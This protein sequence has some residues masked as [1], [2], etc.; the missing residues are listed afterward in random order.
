MS[1]WDTVT[2]NLKMREEAIDDDV[3]DVVSS[4]WLD[5]GR[6]MNDAI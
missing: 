5:V 2:I 3:F 1:L 4:L 6:P